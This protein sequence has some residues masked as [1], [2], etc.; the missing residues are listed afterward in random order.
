[1]LVA[2]F[3]GRIRHCVL[4]DLA[5]GVVSRDYFLEKLADA[6]LEPVWILAGEKNAYAGQGIGG[7]NGGF[8]GRLSHTT[9]VAMEAGHA[10]VTW[11]QD[12]VPCANQMPARKAEG[13]QPFSVLIGWVH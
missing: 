10:E 8:G 11:H 13:Q 7:S 9:V 5:R 1:M 4:P 3:V 6:G 12:R 2:P